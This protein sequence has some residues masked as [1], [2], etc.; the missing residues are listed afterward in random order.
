MAD[1]V[2]T[3]VTV[4]GPQ[5]SSSGTSSTSAGGTKPSKTSQQQNVP[6]EEVAIGVAAAGAVA[7]L[8]SRGG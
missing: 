8:I 6:I 5:G 3:T 7:Y 4:P 2:C 1:K